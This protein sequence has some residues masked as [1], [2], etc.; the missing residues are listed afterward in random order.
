M[1]R[2]LW[3]ILLFVLVLSGCSAFEEKDETRGWS[4]QKLFT[5]ATA[6]M[7]AGNYEKAIKYYEI[8][9]SRYPFGKY[10]HQAQINVVFTRIFF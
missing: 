7:N 6:E 3:P 10:A 9:E 5:E 8:L 4:Q 1:S 2:T